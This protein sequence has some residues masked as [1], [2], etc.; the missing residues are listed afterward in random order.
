MSASCSN[1]CACCSVDLKKAPRYVLDFRACG[2]CLVRHHSTGTTAP[3]DLPHADELQSRPRFKGESQKTIWKVK[4]R[5][6]S[7]RQYHGKRWLL[8]DNLQLGQV[9][10]PALSGQAASSILAMPG[11][12]GAAAYCCIIIRVAV[13]RRPLARALNILPGRV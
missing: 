10:R 6:S 8:Q 9:L 3:L 2:T 1:Q 12:G 5:R 11:I 4:V 13:L 7:C